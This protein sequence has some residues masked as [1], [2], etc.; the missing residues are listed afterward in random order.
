MKKA[1]KFMIVTIGDILQV[2]LNVENENTYLIDF[3]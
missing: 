1:L 2:L 3:N